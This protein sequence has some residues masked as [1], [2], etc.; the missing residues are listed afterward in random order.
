MKS[1]GIY[2]TPGGTILFHSHMDIELL[3]MDRVRIILKKFN[4][5]KLIKYNLFS[6]KGSEKNQTIIN[7]SI[8][9]NNLQW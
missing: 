4:L 2:E 9:R 6:K 3:T 1:R 8:C 7:G 5:F